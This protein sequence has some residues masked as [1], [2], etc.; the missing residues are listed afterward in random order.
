M[1]REQPSTFDDRASNEVE[2]TIQ[3]SEQMDK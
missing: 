1:F 3:D 2:I